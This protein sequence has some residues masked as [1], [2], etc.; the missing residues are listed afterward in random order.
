MKLK[1]IVLIA[2][3]IFV[4]VSTGYLVFNEVREARQPEQAITDGGTPGQAGTRDSVSAAGENKG[5]DRIVRVYYFHGSFRCPTCRR[6]EEYASNA[7]FSGFGPEIKK[8][9]ITWQAV[10]VEEPRNKHFTDDFKLFTRSVVV[11]DEQK[12]KQVRWKVLDKTW[13]LVRDR[14]AFTEY[15]RREVKKYLENV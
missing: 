6:I 5:I 2:L 4:A 3:S 13:E 11:V 9:T 15:I 7:V 10:N 12:G 1:K 14:A 8:G